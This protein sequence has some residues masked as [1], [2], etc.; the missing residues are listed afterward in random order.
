MYRICIDIGGTFTDSVLADGE[1]NINEYK[2]PTTPSDFS[3]GIIDLLREAANTYGKSLEQF[4]GEVSL[5]IHGTTIATNALVQRKLA[6]TALITTKGFRDTIEMRESAAFV[7]EEG[8]IGCGECLAVCRFGAVLFNWG[9]SSELLQ[10]R[11]VEHAYAAV[12]GKEGKVGYMSFLISV[13]KGCDCFGST[14]QPVIPDIGVLAGKDPVALDSIASNLVGNNPENQWFHLPGGESC[15]NYLKLAGDLGMGTNILDKIQLVGNGA[16]H[17]SVPY[18]AD[19]P[20]KIQLFQNHPNPF[21]HSTIIRYYLPRSGHVTLRIH[22]NTGQ[23]VETLV[24][25]YTV[26]GEHQ[27]R[28]SHNDLP[29]GIYFCRLQAGSEINTIKLLFNKN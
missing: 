27:L 13:T 22:N 6:R 1:G 2:V 25:Q 12:K 18:S 4:I 26:A 5:I 16:T 9:V 8:C 7:V 15:D 24:N 21:N 28:W 19:R 14:Q 20:A 3:D 11:V 17:A 23:V 29:A 10:K